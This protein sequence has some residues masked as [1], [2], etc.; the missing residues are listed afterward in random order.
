MTID[1]LINSP[2]SNWLTKC[3]D[4][5]DIVL[6]TVG[7]LVRNLSGYR[8]P[9]WS[10][11]E[12]RDSVSRI[13]LPVLRGLRGFRDAVCAEMSELSFEQRRALLVR[14]QLTPC[15]AARQSGCHLLLPLKRN[16]VCMVNEEEHLVIHVSRS[17][18]SVRETLTDLRKLAAEIEQKVSFARDSRN[19]FLTSMPG[20]AGD[21]IQIYSMLHLPALS[22]ANMIPQV[23]KAMEKL[24]LSI[25][26]YYSDGEDDTGN[27]FIVYTIPGPPGS[28]DEM[29]AHFR[30]VLKDIV[31]REMQVR[32][33]LAEEPGFVL[34]DKVARAYATLGYARRLSLRECRNAISVLRLGRVLGM[35]QEDEREDIR[36]SL[37]RFRELDTALALCT[38]LSPADEEA[39]YPIA[40]AIMTRRFLADIHINFSNS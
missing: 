31:T 24:H 19:G 3:R 30:S 21:G 1:E 18:N 40:R 25:S 11:R 22:I 6:G 28:T 2:I 10:T 9:G 12:D 4:T 35:I 26:P 17:G 38:A 8:F 27:M 39:A 13:L 33:R 29:T 34:E 5:D 37:R 14:K 32:R 16:V 7:R 20:E 23:S 15:M 36:E